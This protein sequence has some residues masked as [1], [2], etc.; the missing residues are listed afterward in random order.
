L[1]VKAI[2]ISTLLGTPP[3]YG[4]SLDNPFIHEERGKHSSDKQLKPENR[5]KDP[6]K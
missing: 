5:E 6:L 3:L 4:L 1:A 2:I